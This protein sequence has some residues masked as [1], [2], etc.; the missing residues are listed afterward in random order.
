MST[1]DDIL[2]MLLEHR[3]ETV[4]GEWMSDQ[5]GISRA[6][7]CAHIRVLRG[8]MEIQSKTNGGYCLRAL[9]DILHPAVYR[10]LRGSGEIG[11]R[12]LFLPEV[13]STNAEAKR[14]CI[15]GRGA[16][17]LV[18]ADTQSAG[19]G[20][21]GRT[22]VSA[23]GQGL[24]MS[25]VVKPSIDLSEVQKVT[26]LTA[27]AVC[28]A[29]R[30]CDAALPLQVK[31]PNDILLNGKKLCGILCEMISDLDGVHFVIL[32]IGINLHTPPGG[33]APDIADKAT[34]LEE[35][36]ACPGRAELAAAISKKVEEYLKIWETGFAPVARAYR[37]YLMP[38]GTPV[39][40]M[41]YD[42]TPREAVF[43][44]VDDDGGLLVDTQTGRERIISGEIAV[45]GR[46]G[47]V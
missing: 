1:R 24:W 18:A 23:P 30:Q 32:G 14:R 34:A 13:D 3:G 10:T 27:A 12:A 33:F 25:L 45:R 40:V 39:R 4:S 19:R 41:G 43:A 35:Y 42:G 29:L 46:N 31:W 7:V 8:E 5:L 37:Q 21:K 38:A 6:A 11:S 16:G 28:D 22:W 36:T 15:D 47:Y 44:G 9:P 17:L 26:L 20:R 2:Q